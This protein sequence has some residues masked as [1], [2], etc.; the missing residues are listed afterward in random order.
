MLQAASDK[1]FSKLKIIDQRPDTSFLVALFPTAKTAL[2]D[3]PS[4]NAEY[5]YLLYDPDH[6]NYLLEILRIL[7]TYHVVVKLK[8]DWSKEVRFQCTYPYFI[9]VT[10]C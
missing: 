6:H 3:G 8:H 7:Y 4:T 2:D 1:L 5:C 9:M 10:A